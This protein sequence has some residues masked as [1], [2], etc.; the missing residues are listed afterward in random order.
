MNFLNQ[1]LLLVGVF[2]SLNLL[3]LNND[4]IENAL[5]IAK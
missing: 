1:V 2:F 5:L 4:D 3:R